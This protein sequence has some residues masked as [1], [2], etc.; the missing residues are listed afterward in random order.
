LDTRKAPGTSQGRK[1]VMRETVLLVL[2]SV[3]PGL[4]SWVAVMKASL[5]ET[6]G[7]DGAVL[8]GS[9][10][11]HSVCKRIGIQIAIH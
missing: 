2:G 9:Q 6:G 3:L 4:E 7:G 10:S 8:I 11:P 5:K 1:Q